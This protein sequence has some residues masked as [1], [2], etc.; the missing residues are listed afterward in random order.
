LEVEAAPSRGYSATARF[1]KS[2][3]GEPGIAFR[4]R[5]L[6]EARKN[7]FTLYHR[8]LESAEADLDRFMRLR[9]MYYDAFSAFYDRF[10]ALH[11]RDTQGVARRFMAKA[12]TAAD[13]GWVLDLCTGTGSLLAQLRAKLDPNVRVVGVDFSGGMVREARKKTRRL[14]SLHLVVADAGWLP[15]A[16]G[17]FDAVTCSHAFYELKGPM[18]DRALH[19]IA[20]V[21]KRNG[22]FLMMEHDVPTSRSTRALFYVRLALVGSGRARA[23]LRH[24]K[25]ILQAYFT[26]VEKVVAPGGRSKLMVCRGVSPSAG[27]DEAAE[28]ARR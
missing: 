10:V 9:A 21:L 11:S 7:F 8:L 13:G 12:V 5:L 27:P 14:P 26:T 2:S 3:S 17:T 20:R 22:S 16:A 1:W 25:E 6:F 18:R 15:F 23:F 24:E 19:E 4:A 28:H